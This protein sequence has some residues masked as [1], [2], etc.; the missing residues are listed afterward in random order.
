VNQ[1]VINLW[2]EYLF[3]KFS[4]ETPALATYWENFYHYL[5]DNRGLSDAL[6]TYF[7]SF[8]RLATRHVSS[9][10]CKNLPIGEFKEITYLNQDDVFSGMLILQGVSLKGG[11]SITMET[12]L[13]RTDR[14][15]MMNLNMS[16]GPNRLAGLQ[17]SY[18]WLLIS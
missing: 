5:D 18:Y 3:G 1:K 4:P 14:E 6:R 2:D 16:E 12:W 9:T 7:A 15:Q 13:S 11:R 10:Y 8:G 17:V